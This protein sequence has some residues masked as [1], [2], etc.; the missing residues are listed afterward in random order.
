MFD[1]VRTADAGDDAGSPRAIARTVIPSLI[2]VAAVAL[3]LVA[4]RSHAV[5]VV[6]MTTG[7]D[8]PTPYSAMEGRIPQ[9]EQPEETPPPTF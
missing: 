4:I 2:A 1:S 9:P 3:V 5:E 7:P 8:E 6:E